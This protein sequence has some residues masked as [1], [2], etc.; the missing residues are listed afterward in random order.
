MCVD[1]TGRPISTD[2]VKVPGKCDSFQQC[3]IGHQMTRT[4]PEGT[5]FDSD[6]GFCD[7]EENVIC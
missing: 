5:L 4:C 1:F 6:K 2:P 7:W 3:V